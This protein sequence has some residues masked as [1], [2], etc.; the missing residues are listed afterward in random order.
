MCHVQFSVQ[1]SSI[2]DLGVDTALA[3]LEDDN[4]E[5]AAAVAAKEGSRQ[6]KVDIFTDGATN[7]LDGQ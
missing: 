4:E 3:V 5:A 6:R 2:E 7:F 1:G